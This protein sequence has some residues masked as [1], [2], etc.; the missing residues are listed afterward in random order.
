MP[1]SARGDQK[2]LLLVDIDGVVSLFGFDP[3]RRPPGSFHT[4]DGI[5]HFLSATAGEHLLELAGHFEIVWCSGWEE[6]ANDYLPHLLG[7]PGPLPFLRFERAPGRGHAHWKL[8]AI[9]AYCGER[10]LAWVDD[11]F[12]DACEAWADRRSAP[13]L[14]LATAPEAGLQ[15]ADVDRLRE[16]AQ[17]LAA[18]SHAPAA[19]APA[20]GAGAVGDGDGALPATSASGGDAPAAL[21]SSAGVRAKHR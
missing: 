16:F 21:R 3:D 15:D 9:D 17:A 1:L 10:P 13:T 11:A 6:K 12:N 5:P 19:G 14:L 7:L 4:V 8:Q 2:P 18:G 20:V